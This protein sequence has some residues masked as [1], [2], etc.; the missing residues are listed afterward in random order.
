SLIAFL[1]YIGSVYSPLRG[2]ARRTYLVQA[3][4]AGAERVFE[5]LDLDN[6][7]RERSGGIVLG[8]T[9]WAIE[10]DRVAFGYPGG[11]PTLDNFSLRIAPGETVA[12]VG[13]SGVGKTTI[14]SLLLRFYDPQGGRITLDGEDLAGIDLH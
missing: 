7:A 4:A 1:G 10:F 5:M 12:L 2:L 13:E 14:V 11:P 8:R 3:A 9:S 6:S